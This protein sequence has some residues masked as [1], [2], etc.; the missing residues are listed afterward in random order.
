MTATLVPGHVAPSPHPLLAERR[1]TRAFDR[2]HRLDDGTVVSLLEAARW[3]PSSG[4]SQP[5]RFLVTRRGEPEFDRLAA[6]LADG[7]RSWAPGASAL[8][9]AAAAVPGGDQGPGHAW[10]DTGQA[11]THLVLQAHA[12][13]LSARQMGGFDAEAARRGFELAPDVVPVVVVA[14]GRHDPDADLPPRVLEREQ[15]PRTRRPVAEFLL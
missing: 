12:L 11:V 7:N 15:T 3:A 2:S 13:G 9:L 1:S 8:L 10:Y 5:W 6:T 4:N 14:I